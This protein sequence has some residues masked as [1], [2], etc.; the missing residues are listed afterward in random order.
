MSNFA[1]PCTVSS[2]PTTEKLSYTVSE[3]AEASGVSEKTIRRAIDAGD[4]PAYYPTNRPLVLV[5]DLKSW[6]MTDRRS[7]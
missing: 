6:V 1:Y 2:M 3:A 7:A 5:A 4:L